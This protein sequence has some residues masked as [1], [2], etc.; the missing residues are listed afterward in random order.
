[1]LIAALA[2]AALGVAVFWVC[3]LTSAGQRWEDA[4]L[5]GRLRASRTALSAADRNL[6]LITEA[7]LAFAVLVVFAIGLLRRRILL[8]LAGA[9]TICATVFTAEVLKRLVL[10]RPILVPTPSLI[11]ENSFPSGHT[12]I[13]MSTLFGLLLVVPYRL[14]GVAALLTG[15][16]AVSIGEYT[17]TAGWHRTSD[18]IGGDLLALAV[19]CVAAALLATLGRVRDGGPRRFPLR[20]IFVIAPLALIAV[21]GVALGGFLMW[22][23]VVHGTPDAPWTAYLAGSALAR[24]ASAAVALAMLALMRRVDFGTRPAPKPVRRAAEPAF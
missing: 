11:A 19:A 21:T 1:M 16:W 2:A 4:A 6:E 20:T 17:V 8:G 9:G 12:A 7:S 22:S 18:T 24:A 3:D 14:R 10:E 13:A 15:F 23:Q 5:L